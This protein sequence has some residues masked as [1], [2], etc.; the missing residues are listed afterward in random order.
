[1]N[2]PNRIAGDCSLPT[3]NRILS[4]IHVRVN[5]CHSP[6]R[7]ISTKPPDQ[8]ARLGGLAHLFK[9]PSCRLDRPHTSA[10]R[11]AGCGSGC[12]WLR[13]VRVRDGPADPNLR[14]QQL[15]L[16]EVPQGEKLLDLAREEEV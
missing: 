16:L 13:A 2:G 15:D 1:M 14:G 12:S 10:S 6:I 7:S 4:L 5:C 3:E 9:K 11:H 8:F